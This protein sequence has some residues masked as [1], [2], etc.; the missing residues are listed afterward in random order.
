MATYNRRMLFRRTLQGDSLVSGHRPVPIA[1]VDRTE[2]DITVNFRRSRSWAPIHETIDDLDRK[3][4]IQI[5]LRFEDAD[6]DK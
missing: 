2:R 5:T 3:K 1:A 6:K 4:R